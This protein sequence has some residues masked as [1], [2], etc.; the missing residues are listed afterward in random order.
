VNRRKL[1]VVG[2][3]AAAVVGSASSSWAF[4]TLTSDPT[5]TAGAK[6]TQLNG[7]NVVA[8]RN[9]QSGVNAHIQIGI[10]AGP[11]ALPDRFT[12]FRGPDL[13]CDQ[14]P[15]NTLCDET[16]SNNSGDKIY[17]ITAYAGTNWVSAVSTCS[18]KNNNALPDV[19]SSIR[20]QP[21]VGVSSASASSSSTQSGFAASSTDNSKPKGSSTP[22]PTPAPAVITPDPTPTPVVTPDPTPV[23][24]PTPTPVVTPDPT[25][26]PTPDPTPAPAETPSTPAET[27]TSTTDS[28][29]T[30][31]TTDAPA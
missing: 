21:L 30:P 11:G 5:S 8:G 14:I 16:G 13:M 12:V 2:L 23:P 29:T 25:P 22:T 28:T 19:P 20:C 6:A 4:W 10:S 24:D 27:S 9:G 26:V 15:S 18:F 31:P 3:A 17:T 7:A 1:V